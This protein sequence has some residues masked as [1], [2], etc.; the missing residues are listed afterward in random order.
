VAC[1]RRDSTGLIVS[2]RLTPKGG[3]D[4]VDG[5]ATLADGRE[6]IAA[7]VRAPAEKGAANAALAI[8]LAELFERPRS[9][10]EIVAGASGRLKQVAISGDPNTL[11]AIANRLQPR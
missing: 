4:S 1:Y 8:L 5:I 10:V 3:R 7:R 9:A 11:A 2:V 6:V